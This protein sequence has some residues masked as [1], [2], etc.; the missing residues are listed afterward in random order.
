MEV[1]L[2]GG[3]GMS[4]TIKAMRLYLE[5]SKLDGVFY[6]Y[7]ERE[8]DDDETC[9][10]IDDGDKFEYGEPF[11]LVACGDFGKVAP[12]KLIE[13]NILIDSNSLSRTDK[14]LIGVLRELKDKADVH[15]ML[16]IATIPDD[17]EW[18]IESDPEWNTEWV[19]EGLRPRIWYGQPL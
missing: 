18:H 17:I 12:L 10:R 8:D 4:L 6:A 15:K 7:P 16:S 3:F 13:S 11:Y 5:R 1:I 2:T 14:V 9:T 19:V